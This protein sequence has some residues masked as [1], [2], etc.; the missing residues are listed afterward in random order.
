M[1]PMLARSLKLNQIDTYL[2]DDHW[3]AQ[4][5]LD[6]DRILIFIGDGRVQVLNREGE[7]RRNRVPREVL[8]QFQPFTSLPGTWCFDGELMPSGEFW[9]FDLPAAADK[10]TT[11]EPFLRRY[12]VLEHFMAGGDWPTAPCVRLLP[13]AQS[14]AAK[15]ALFTELRDRGAEGLML[16]H[17][18]SRYRS[19]KRSD[20][21]L[22]AKFTFT[23]DVVVHK[24]RPG[25]RNNCSYRLF[26][27][28]TWV[29]AGSCSLEARPEVKP[30]DVIEVRALYAS[31]DG[32]LYQPVMLRVRHD[33]SPTECTV[34]QLQYTDRTVINPVEVSP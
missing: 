1:K 30:G 11:D 22:K 21:M 19:G 17:I 14:T 5:K 7:L 3:V 33:K 34:A 32:L 12:R 26:D 10:V 9:I 20:L 24:V 8:E 13:L 4:Q 16:R 18:D 2:T 25:G 29:P 27:N 6:G 23:V 28:G 31:A 15:R